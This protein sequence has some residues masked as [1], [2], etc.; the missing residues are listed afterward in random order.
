MNIEKVLLEINDLNSKLRSLHLKI[1]DEQ[2]DS[3]TLDI[4]SID[5]L[6][7]SVEHTH[8][9]SKNIYDSVKDNFK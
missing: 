1:I 8:T 4:A 9:V 2:F 7:C 5:A 6:Y 3:S